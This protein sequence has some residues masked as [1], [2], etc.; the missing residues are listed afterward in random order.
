LIERTI[1]QSA[2]ECGFHAGAV[3]HGR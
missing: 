2:V 1:K 3:S